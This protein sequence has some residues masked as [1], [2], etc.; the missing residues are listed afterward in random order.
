MTGALAP[1]AP[2]QGPSVRTPGG[3]AEVMGDGTTA[4][5]RALSRWRRARWPV[6][7]VVVVIV[8]ALLAAVLK[9]RTSQTPF[10]P[11]NATGSGG[12]ALAEI[13]G[14]QG[15]SVDLVRTS[16]EAVA[17]ADAGT[18]L[19]V[20]GSYLLTDS[21]IDAL[22]STDADLVV[23]GPESWHLEQLSG[24]RLTTSLSPTGPL[25]VAA[26]CSDPDA[27]AAGSI[28]SE[29]Y[30]V[31][32]LTPD[33]VVCF[34]T[35]SPDVTSVG[36]AGA[37]AAV[38]V[39]GRRLVVIDDVTLITNDRLAQDGNAALLLRTLGHNARLTW[40]VPSLDDTGQDT[41]AAPSGEVVPGWFGPVG[42]QLAL[43]VLVLALWRGRALGRIVTEPLPVTIRAAEATV[44]R[45]RLYRR[46]R[47]RGHAAAALRAGTARRAALRL[48][49]PRAAG[50]H[51]V[52]EALAQATGQSTDQVAA[53]LYGPPPTDDAALLQLAH[54]LDELESEVH[55]T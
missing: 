12:R 32:A 5:S 35:D 36:G 3:P 43:V 26:G 11:D 34:P 22:A 8:A 10:G 37:Y 51:Q 24:G 48:G 46:S 44:G 14:R 18:T 6:T 21:Q 25:A 4:R 7:V 33:V 16:A 52:I 40:Y 31:S 27:Q 47:S 17:R 13:L 38:T 41:A 1:V 15:V 9:P 28:R 19:L 53:L 2:S 54:R 39:H 20:V 55:R 29:G 42:A 50:A 45:G 30:G 23:V 49:L